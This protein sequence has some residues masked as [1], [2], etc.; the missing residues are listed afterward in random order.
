MKTAVVLGT[1]PEITKLAPVI[2][3]LE[4]HAAPY[5]LIHTGQ[6]FSY[7]MDKVFFE[8]LDLPEPTLNLGAGQ[9][10]AKHGAQTG[11]M[12]QRLEAAFFDLGIDR[13]IVH[14]DTNSTLAGALVAAKLNM[15]IGHVEAGLRSFD[16]TMPEEV[17]R[18]VADHVASLLF[19]PTAVARA[20]LEREGITAGIEVTGNTIV[21]TVYH[22]RG[23]FEQ[24]ATIQGLG[25]ASKR[26]IYLT[27]H[28]QEN[29]DDPERLRRILGG[30]RLAALDTGFPI[31]F[32]MH[33]RTKDRVAA[34]GMEDLLE[35]IPGLIVLHPPVGLFESLELQHHARLVM[36]DS[37]GLQEESC[38]LGTPCVTIRENTE[39]PETLA[40][41]C[42]ALAGYRE[43][44][45]LAAVKEMLERGPGWP[46]PFGDGLAGARCVATLLGRPDLHP[47][48]LA[49]LGEGV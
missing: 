46:N 16:R 30:L 28:R 9:A 17:N 36:T 40:I 27:L 42:N 23:T 6:H 14:G 2:W 29:V 7:E 20:N 4:Q 43:E 48:P 31:V 10:G 13:A 49:P 45:I 22:L 41:G 38:I 26:F 3:A 35:A 1:R 25:V 11:L 21:D 47:G 39:R 12:L 33:Y 44:T 37:G 5:A 8:T 19:A 32:S 18:V 34:Y 24:G 15:P